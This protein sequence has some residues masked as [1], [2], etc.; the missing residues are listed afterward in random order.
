MPK[1]QHQV[2][3]AEVLLMEQ[4]QAALEQVYKEIMVVAH[5]EQALQ[6]FQQLVVVV[7]EQLELMLQVADQMQVQVV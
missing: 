4:I 6:I 5:Q 3:Q 7:Q 1:Q 2:V